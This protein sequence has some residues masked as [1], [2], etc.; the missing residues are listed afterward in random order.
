VNLERLGSITS[1]L[2]T[3]LLKSIVV[4]QG[5]LRAWFAR[6]RSSGQKHRNGRPEGRPERELDV[7]TA[8]FPEG[9]VILMGGM[10]VPDEAVVAALHLCGGRSS[11]VAVVPAAA[12]GDSG[13]AAAAAA[14]AFTRFGM[15]QVET[16]LLDAREKAADPAWAARL[17]EFD[18]IVL[19]GDSPSRGLHVLQATAAATALREHVQ[20]GRLLVGIDAGGAIL[21][22]RLFPHETEDGI[23]VGLGILPALLIDS[24]FSGAR[25]FSRLVRAMSAP[26]AAAMMGVG[27]DA[28]TAVLV[29]QGEAKVLGEATVTVLDPWERGAPSDD[30]PGGM[31]V[32]LLTD[33]YRLNFRTRRAFPPERQDGEAR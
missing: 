14:R 20:A 12:S 32:H 8:E 7:S 17:R 6:H 18:A 13:E 28:Q 26:E 23:T 24:G 2:S 27:L 10:P 30:R 5:G 1:E 15:K 29:S 16:V 19:C 9:P 31:K 4:P 11:R 22:S 21:G 3:S 33:G 25:R